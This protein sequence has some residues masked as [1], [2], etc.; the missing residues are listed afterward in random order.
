MDGCGRENGFQA[1]GA[2]VKDIAVNNWAC[3]NEPNNIEANTPEIVVDNNIRTAK[4]IL[5]HIPDAPVVV[6]DKS[7]V[8]KDRK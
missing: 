8:V 2:A 7:L 4:I 3:W 6:T 1:C 5:K